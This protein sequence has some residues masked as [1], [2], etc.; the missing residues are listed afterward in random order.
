MRALA[1]GLAWPEGPALLPDGRVAFVE[2]YAS[3][4][5]TWSP[6]GG[7]RLLADT[8]GG[9]NAVAL[10]AD[11]CLYL[12]QNGGVVGPWRAPQQRRPSIERV[13]LDG[14]VETLVTE[15]GG[16]PLLAPNDLAFDAAGR[17]WF[18]DPGR[19][20]AQTRP[21]SGRVVA[22]AADGR[23]EVVLDVGPVYPNGIVAEADGAVVWVES[24]TR[25]VRRR[26]PDG[27]VELLAVL[28]DGHVPDGL[29]VAADG[30]LWVTSVTSGGIDVLDARGGV[31][32]VAVGAVPTNCAFAGSTLYVTD[33]GR[34]GEGETAEA[35]GALW[36][37]ETGV[38]GAA[39]FRGVVAVGR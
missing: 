36:A 2:T 15:V 9:P 17:L 14:A 20:D 37:L 34:P 7:R 11:D 13:T 18:T 25:A 1:T 12:C 38:A 32:F 39:P 22:L 8:G 28:D 26:R 19:Y 21:D 29:A 3:R 27:E 33:G 31:R 35:S 4:I 6:A 16:E 30:S 23:P 10:G 5:S 24:Y